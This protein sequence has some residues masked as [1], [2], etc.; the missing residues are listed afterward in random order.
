MWQ[1]IL[2]PPPKSHKKK[3]KEYNPGIVPS[4][5]QLYSTVSGPRLRHLPQGGSCKAG[6]QQAIQVYKRL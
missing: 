5:E 3:P 2:L 1:I 6:E 4:T